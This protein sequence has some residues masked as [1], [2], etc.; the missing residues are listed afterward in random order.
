MT[1]QEPPRLLFE[2]FLRRRDAD[3]NAPTEDLLA[4]AGDQRRE[5][6][7]RIELYQ[8]LLELP[9]VLAEEPLV[10]AMPAHRLGRFESLE[11]IGKGGLSQVY[12]ALDTSLDRNIALKV[13]D[14]ARIP[15]SDTRTWRESEGKALAQLDHAGIVRVFEVGE[16]EGHAYIAMEFVAGPSLQSVIEALRI[17]AAP[18]PGLTVAESV[19]AS[20]RALET[21]SARALCALWIAEA[22]TYSHEKGVLHR[23]IKPGNVLIGPEQKPKLIDF[24]LAS[25][26]VERDDARDLANNLV[27]TPAYLAPEQVDTRRTGSSRQSEVFSFGTL[28]Y[29]LLTLHNPF[30]RA[31]REETMAAVSRALPQRLRAIDRAIP[32][33]LEV[34]CLRCL[35]RKPERRYASMRAVADDLRAF[36][37]HRAISIE[38]S[39]WKHAVLFARRHRRD[40][41]LG[42]ALAAF[43][44]LAGCVAWLVSASKVRTRLSEE[45]DAW[46]ARWLDAETP[47][48]FQQAF[49]Q[50]RTLHARSEQIDRDGISWIAGTA[51]SETEAA[52]R[53]LSQRLAQVFGE[54]LAAARSRTPPIDEFAERELFL[55]YAT[56]FGVERTVCPDC[57]YNRRERE[58]GMIDQPPLADGERIVVWAPTADDMLWSS[59]LNERAF[60]QSPFPGTYR[61]G[62][63]GAAGA[64]LSEIEIDV[65]PEHT[66]R[67]I[68]LPL[69]SEALLAQMT[70]VEGGKVLA[71]V[72]RGDAYAKT[73]LISSEYITWRLLQRVADGGSTIP[74]RVARELQRISNAPVSPSPGPAPPGLDDPAQL[75]WEDAQAFLGTAGMRLPTWSERLLARESG[76]AAFEDDPSHIELLSAPAMGGERACWTIHKLTR[77]PT[78]RMLRQD[79][80]AN[81]VFRAAFSVP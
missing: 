23:D 70:R 26:R 71:P 34:I 8:V 61:I 66:R 58:R 73:F 75:T 80:T 54:K 47:T 76:G 17:R 1:A 38:A 79:G 67:T 35:E 65:R 14:P 45:L 44:V 11:L 27:G 22:L 20:A 52:I 13:L 39:P 43:L 9:K 53:T 60:E 48:E 81:T 3:P 59:A 12:R 32:T 4:R 7:Q 56:T 41:V 30:D 25:A 69:R 36:L 10:A 40:L 77:K 72:G 74:T 28:L 55:N 33:D 15:I 62:R 5:L 42:G 78:A 63:F 31:T 37:T 21:L 50:V 24:G 64:L 19:A 29:E 49:E 51:V 18:R 6:E 57:D 2:E 46:S 68:T 16:E